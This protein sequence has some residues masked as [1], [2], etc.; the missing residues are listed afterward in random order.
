MVRQKDLVPRVLFTITKVNYHGRMT[1]QQ[2]EIVKDSRDYRNIMR[3]YASYKRWGKVMVS[4]IPALRQ[5]ETV[6]MTE[7]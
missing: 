7:I 4:Y 1:V 2:I 3:R 6:I 5:Q